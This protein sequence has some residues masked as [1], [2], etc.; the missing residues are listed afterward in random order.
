M[1]KIGRNDPCSCGSGKKYKRC[2]Y[3]IDSSR[4]TNKELVKMRKKF[5]EDSRKRIYVLQKHGIFIDFV[6][7]AI[8][9]EKSIWALGSRLYPNE[10]PN[11]TFHEFLLSALAQELG[12]EWILDQENKTLEQRHFIMKCH[13]Y[14]KEWK[15][16]E[17]KHPEDPNNN[18]TIWSN[19][20]D[21]YSKSLISLAFDF[22]CIIHINGQV[23]K[24]I[25]DRLKLMDS[26]YQG[27]RYEIMV[28]GILSR[29]DCKLEYLDEKYK[30]EKKTPKHNEFLVTDPS[31]KFSFSVEAK[32]KVRK[33]V[34]HE[35]GQIIP[36]QLWN[37]A[38]KPYKDA[39]N[40]QIPENIAY[41]VFADVNSPPTPELSIEKKP[42]FKKILENRKNTPVNKPG[43]LDP[44]SAIVYTNYSYHYQTQNESNTNE[45]V[46]VIPQ[47][48]KYILPE[49]LVIKFQHTLNGYSYI[50]DIKYDGT[51]RS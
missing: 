21:G 33:G 26:N 48:A 1:N 7:P 40:D 41:V 19:V 47:Y 50:P 9:K 27:A 8:F 2:H 35:E 18:E 22:A 3:L 34:L 43:N 25:I 10:K 14:Y 11:I 49:A 51:I 38:T 12:K 42:Y 44:C 36:Y 30:H 28:A 5:A 31:T 15:N 39:I 6:A 20:P 17:N 24:Q 29:M 37:N 32:S 4:P 23:P 45:A 13:H 16:K 46:L